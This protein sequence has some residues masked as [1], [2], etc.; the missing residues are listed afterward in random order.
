MK[1]ILL[2]SILLLTGCGSEAN[3]LQAVRLRF[4]D[5]EVVKIPD[6][7]DHYIIRK[8]DGSVWVADTAYETDQAAAVWNNV[9]LL[10]PTQQPMVL[11]EKAE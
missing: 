7:E 4:P 10:P 9:Q 5:S 3:R 6:W 8:P 11:P 1:K 2:L